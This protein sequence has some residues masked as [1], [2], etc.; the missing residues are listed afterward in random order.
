[1]ID[2]PALLRAG[3]RSDIADH[4]FIVEIETDEP[5]EGL[6]QSIEFLRTVRV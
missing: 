3:M 5:L 2:W 1:M 4:G 6:R